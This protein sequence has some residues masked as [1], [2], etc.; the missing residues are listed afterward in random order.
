MIL[1]ALLIVAS[2]ASVGASEDPLDPAKGGSVQCYMPDEGRRTCRSIASYVPIDS[3][4]YA[5]KAMVLIAREGPIILET[6]TPVTLKAG[7][8]CGFIREEDIRAGKLYVGRGLLPASKASPLLE[9]LAHSSSWAKDMEICTTYV[10]T[11]DGLIA[12]VAYDG[13]YQKNSDQHVKWVRP[14]DGYSVA[15]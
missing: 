12:K 7:A 15:P 14:S 8:V 5:N 11:R 1:V 3:G 13:D 2:T 6:V 10:P 9:Q 4:T